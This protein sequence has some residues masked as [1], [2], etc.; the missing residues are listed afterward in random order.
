MGIARYVSRSL[1][2]TSSRGLGPQRHVSLMYPV[3]WMSLVGHYKMQFL[4]NDG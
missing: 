1:A 2:P 4:L 3:T